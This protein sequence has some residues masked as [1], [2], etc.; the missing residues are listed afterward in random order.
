MPKITTC[1]RSSLV[2]KRG[3]SLCTYALMIEISFMAG[4]MNI[5]VDLISSRINF[6]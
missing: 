3:R 2:S 1:K 4:L 6:M 5:Q